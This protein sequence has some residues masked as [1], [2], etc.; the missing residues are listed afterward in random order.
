MLKTTA[1][2]IASAAAPAQTSSGSTSTSAVSA[3]AET[4]NPTIRIKKDKPTQV[5]ATADAGKPDSG[6][7][8][9]G[10][11]DATKSS[12][13][14]AAQLNGATACCNRQTT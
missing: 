9:S 3:D 8:D 14:F 1:A 13:D 4:I 2:Q 5:I 12:A 11:S 6:N 10:K 7:T